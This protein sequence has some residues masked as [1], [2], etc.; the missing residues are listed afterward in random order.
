MRKHLLVLLL[1]TGCATKQVTP[2][3]KLIQA[4]SKIVFTESQVS[5]AEAPPVMR[6]CAWDYTNQTPNLIFEVWATTNLME[7]FQLVLET[8]N[9]RALFPVKQQEFY[10]VRTKDLNTS[11]V[12]DWATTRQN[13]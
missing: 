5:A 9:T 11:L 10:K 2:L 12:S 1:V 13:Q 6:G 8:T 4:Q 7:A 3:P